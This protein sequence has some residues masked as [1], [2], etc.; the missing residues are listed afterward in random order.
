MGT[1]MKGIYKSF[2]YISQIFFVKDREME[3][4]YPTDVKHVA[5][6]GWDGQSG[7][8]PSSMNEFRAAPDF[9]SSFGNPM[10]SSN[11]ALS[12]WSFQDFEQSMGGKLGSDIFKDIAPTDLPNIP[13]KQKQKKKSSTSSP[14][15]GSSRSSR[16]VKSKTTYNEMGTTNVQV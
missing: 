6:I 14:K 2:K 8:A 5:H 4:G 1:K 16:S 3:I 15:C 7:T 13:K 10:D 9:S 11:M 12:A